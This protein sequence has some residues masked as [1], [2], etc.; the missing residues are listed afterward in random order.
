MLNTELDYEMLQSLLVGNS[1]AFYDDAEKI[2]PGISNCEYTLGTVRKYKLR[3]VIEKGKEL[4]EPAQSIFMVPETFK[5]ARIL[6][7]EFNPE[8][9]FDAHFENFEKK[10]S[11]QL[12]PMKMNFVIKAQKKITIDIEYSKVVLNEEQVFPFKIPDNYEPIVFKEKQ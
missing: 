3:R 6:F 8:R 10:D 1:V 5:I 9:S 2:K 11:T 7:Y 4:K 12:F